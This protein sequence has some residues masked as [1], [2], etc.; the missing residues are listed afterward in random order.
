M[1]IRICFFILLFLVSVRSGRSFYFV[2]AVR[3]GYFMVI[4]EVARWRFFV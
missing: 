2:V 4:G 3:K 1:F